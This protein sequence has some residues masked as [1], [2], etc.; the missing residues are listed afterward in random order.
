MHRHVQPEILDELAADDPRA[1]QSRRDLQKVNTFMGHRGLVT[2]ALRSAPASPQFV[3][4]LG[5]GDGTFLLNVARHLA[6]GTRVRAVLVDRRPSLSTAT[7]KGFEQAGW[8]V[9]MP[10]GRL[11]M[12][13]PARRRNSGRDGGE[14]LP[15]PLPGSESWLTC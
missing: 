1:I 2:N 12:A 8:E 5:A 7:R 14:P 10:G 13:L 15:P 4:E 9:D 6:S 3:I 11:R